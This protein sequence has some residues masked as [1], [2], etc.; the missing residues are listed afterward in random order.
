MFE[1]G[2]KHFWVVTINFFTVIPLRLIL[3][4]KR[5]VEYDERL[6]PRTDLSADSFAFPST[7]SYL[8]VVIMGHLFLAL[9]TLW[10]LPIAL[11][12]VFL[13]GFSRI[14]SR[15][16]F[17]HQILGSYFLGFL[18]LLG[19]MHCCEKMSFHMMDHQEHGICVGIAG[20]FFLCGIAMSMENNES[21]LLYVPK[22][23][24]VKV[25]SDILSGGRDVA[26]NDED[27]QLAAEASQQGEN[28]ID[29]N[30]PRNN[31]NRT[32]KESP[33][34]IALQEAQSGSGSN[35]LTAR[36]KAY[37]KSDSLYYL[38][39]SLEEREAKLKEEIL[40][41]KNLY[42]ASRDRYN[43]KSKFSY[44]TEDFFSSDEDHEE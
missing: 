35:T 3:E 13:V 25:L 9:K 1:V 6:K 36:K 39:K 19:S 29:P 23:E 30:N 22:Q 15:A 10:F 2:T 20:A 8:S 21:Y 17:P 41:K 14:Y 32:V 37:V 18:G 40:Q 24:F 7:E 16:R 31:R 11:I 28:E 12:V 26:V 27:N 43:R 33:R 4:V 44:G 5:P 34:T 42:N 38:Q